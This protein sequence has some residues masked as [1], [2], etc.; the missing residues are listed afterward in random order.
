MR[1]MVAM[2]G[3]VDSSVAAA[4]MVEA[5]HEV[6]GVTMKLRDTTPE[7]R[8]GRSASCCSPDD[9]MDARLVCDTLGIAHYVVDYRE[10]FLRTVIQPFAED[11]LAGL[12]PNPCVRCNDHVKFTP[13]LERARM[14]GAERLVTGHYAR[15]TD[16]PDGA[17]ALRA[18]IDRHKDQSYFLFGL[19]QAILR[20]VDFPLGELDKGAVRDKAR[21]MG[22]PNWDKADSEDICFVPQGDYSEVVERVVGAER[23][24]GEGPIEHI[25][26]RVLGDHRG[27]HRYTVGQRKGLGVATGERL[28]VIGV[29]ADR[30][31][32]TVGPRAAL[33]AAGLRAA[34][35]NWISGAAPPM[36]ARGRIRIRYRHHGVDGEVI[37]DGDRAL[38]RFD[39]PQVAVAPGQAAVVYADDRVLGGGWIE[40]ALP[41]AVSSSEAGRAG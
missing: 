13:L 5:G 22:L 24:P 9:L 37:A 10:L 20:R 34:A 6:I 39:S 8:A 14:L 23:T 11:Y 12:T 29:D 21:E 28:Y 7:E 17:R 18:A 25:D 2:S 32:V 35:C 40:R 16:E 4:L 1:V 27:V 41:A 19:D 36:G 31:A 30:S 38:M 15:L 33:Q 26:G 3:G